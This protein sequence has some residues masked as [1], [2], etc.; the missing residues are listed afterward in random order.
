MNR[1]H[2]WRWSHVPVR[3]GTCRVARA[4]HARVAV[5]TRARHRHTLAARAGNTTI[6]QPPIA[7]VVV[8]DVRLN[9]NFG[10]ER[11]VVTSLHD[12]MI[13]AGYKN[14]IRPF[15]YINLNFR[16]HRL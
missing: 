13:A 11:Y 7:G 3:G 4:Y 1:L 15:F 6:A 9:I 12:C 14:V 2:Q 8:C 16:R 10:V 5:A